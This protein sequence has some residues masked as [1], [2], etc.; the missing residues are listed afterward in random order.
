MSSGRQDYANNNPN[1]ILRDG[2]VAWTADQSVGGFLLTGLGTCVLSTDAANKAYVDAQIAAGLSNATPQSVGTAVPGVGTSVSRDDHVHAH[3]NQATSASALHALVVAAGNSGF[4]SGT[5]KTK[6]DASGI[7]DT[8]AADIQ[9]V[10]TQAAGATGKA[11]D[12]GHIHAH[13]NQLGGA[14]HADVV[15]GTSSGFISAASQTKL[16]G[17]AT[18][19]TNTPL[20]AATPQAVG[21]A[22]AGTGTSA[23]KNDHVHA[24]GNLSGD[25]SS[26]A[27]VTTIG[28][29]KVTNSMLAQIA[30]QYIKGRTTAGTG[31]LEDLTANQALQVIGAIFNALAAANATQA[32][33]L[34]AKATSGDT[35][36]ATTLSADFVATYTILSARPVVG[37]R[38]R[39]TVGGALTVVGL[40][41]NTLTL[42]L[43]LGALTIA[44]GVSTTTL[45]TADTFQIVADITFSSVTTN[46]TL[47]SVANFWLG[48]SGAG[49]LTSGVQTIN[50]NASLAVANE[51]V[52]LTAAWLNNTGSNNNTARLDTFI[53]EIVG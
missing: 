38:L 36:V 34:Y 10:G 25:V 43:K 49:T 37:C 39:I 15:A 32:T 20:S 14:L 22:T 31:N 50:Q 23:S 42:T 27:L 16:D 48:R 30:S 6:L 1:A 5:D 19:A 41:T 53:V 40:A 3:G 45:T 11:A 13:G 46:F 52:V 9:P 2:T 8:T 44:T 33:V 24:M 47:N 35:R 21:T 4:M 7:L 51:A 28:A 29:N 12:A 26:A 17:I 18:G